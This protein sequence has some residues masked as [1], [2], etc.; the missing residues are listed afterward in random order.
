MQT[1]KFIFINLPPINNWIPISL[2]PSSF[3]T[4]R[5][6]MFKVD[7]S[8]AVTPSSSSSLTLPSTNNFDFE[9]SFCDDGTTGDLFDSFT[10][11]GPG[12]D[13]ADSSRVKMEPLEEDGDDEGMPLS[14]DPGGF[15]DTGTPTST[16][17]GIL[18]ES[19]S[20]SKNGTIS[21]SKLEDSVK[22]EKNPG[23]HATPTTTTPTAAL[24]VGGGNKKGETFLKSL[25][26]ISTLI[27]GKHHFN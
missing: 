21:S 6:T 14:R 24:L 13:P 3:L 16:S 23:P 15:G 19:T 4:H 1:F 2:L 25:C 5:P 8:S 22:R 10:S 27:D 11:P 12:M 18:V 17:S 20:G 26:P 9:L 7:S